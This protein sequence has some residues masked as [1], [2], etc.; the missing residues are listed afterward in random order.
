MPARKS[1]PNMIDGFSS[2][3]AIK[4]SGKGKHE[5]R[6]R[7][8]S[9]RLPNAEKLKEKPAAE[10]PKPTASRIGHTAMPEKHE[11][12]CYVCDYAFKLTGRIDKT[13]CPKCRKQLDT[14]NYVISGAWETDIRTM[15]TI[16]VKTGGLAGKTTFICQNIVIAGDVRQASI[17]ACRRLEI[18]EGAQIDFAHVTCKDLIVQA[19]ARTD[20]RQPLRLRHVEISGHFT[21]NLDVADTVI[22]RAGGFFK[23]TLRTPR[24]IM[25]DGA[26]LNATLHLGPDAREDAKAQAA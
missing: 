12:V 18:R 13:F 15:G 14:A 22:I 10:T 1:S 17:Q 3:Q 2:V 4:H 26:G 23:G 25:E 7:E 19:G 16:D 8:S 5:A 24:L 20:V 9:S 11:L 6:T 21:G